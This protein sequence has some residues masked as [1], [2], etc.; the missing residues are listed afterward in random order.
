[1]KRKKQPMKTILRRTNE[2]A[3]II[4]LIGIA[5]LLRRTNEIAWI[6]SLIGI[7]SL[8]FRALLVLD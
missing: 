6:V 2:I 7:A 1:M 3:W 5:S 8:Q 4:L